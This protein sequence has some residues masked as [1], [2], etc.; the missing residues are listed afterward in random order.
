MYR[1]V[2][3][4]KHFENNRTKEIK[5]LT[6]VPFPNSHDGDGYTELLDHPNGAAHYGCWCAIVQIASKCD[7]RGTLLRDGAREHDARSL[8]RMARIPEALMAEAIA[9]LVDPVKWLEI[10]PFSVVPQTAAPACGAVALP[11]GLPEQN[12]TE[13]NSDSAEGAMPP[14][15]EVLKEPT[16]EEILREYG[17]LDSAVPRGRGDR[18]FLTPIAWLLAAGHPIRPAV[19][20]AVDTVRT[21]QPQPEN[22]M[23]YLRTLL[24][25]SLGKQRLDYLI[26]QVPERMPQEEPVHD[27]G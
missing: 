16:R 14:H 7:P 9:R 1:V 24:K 21:M 26:A 5:H 23:G 12:R 27:T 3:W 11:C 6:W 10:V 2:N 18:R 13:L 17:F 19:V 20:A 22:P 8:G 15:A 25:R 4:D